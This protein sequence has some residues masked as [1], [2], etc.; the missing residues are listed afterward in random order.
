MLQQNI[1][2]KACDLGLWTISVLWWLQRL[3]GQAE[4]HQ[5]AVMV[6]GVGQGSL[7]CNDDKRG[8]LGSTRVCDGYRC[9][10]RVTRAAMMATVNVTITQQITLY[11]LDQYYL[12]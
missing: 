7:E 10:L 2:Q 4:E 8:S 5:S 11:L 9:R 1:Q 6:A 3:Q 12:R